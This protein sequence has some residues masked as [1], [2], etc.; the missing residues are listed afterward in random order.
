M[1]TYIKKQNLKSFLLLVGLAF[2]FHRTSL[3]C[4]PFYWIIPRIK[5]GNRF[6]QTLVVLACIITGTFLKDR[7]WTFIQGFEA[8]RYAHYV[9]A[10]FDYGNSGSGLGVI[11]N[12]FRYFIII[13]Y[14]DV[15]KCKYKEQGFNIFYCLTFIDM[16][17]YSAVKDDLALS[18]MLMYFTSANIITT[19]FLLYYLSK[20]N[21]VFDKLVLM[22]LMLMFLTIM[23]YTA[24]NS[25]TWNFII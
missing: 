24:Y 19:S 21:K 15:L 10:V 7:L 4:I 13:Y 5:L 9:D 3:L 11:A 16:C 8:L 2:C 25:P 14:S 12:Y 6:V 23:L 17:L 1:N 20:S 18:R 22:M